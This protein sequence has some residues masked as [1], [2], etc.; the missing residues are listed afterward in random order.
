MRNAGALLSTAGGKL[1]AFPDDYATLREQ[2]LA[3]SFISRPNAAWRPKSR[4]ISTALW[5]N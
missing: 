3:G 2:Q 4:W 1:P 5:S